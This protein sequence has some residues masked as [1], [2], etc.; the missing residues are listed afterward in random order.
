MDRAEEV[1][2]VIVIGGGPAGLAAAVWCRR[3]GLDV[4]LLEGGENP[5]GQLLEHVL[6]LVD[7]PG[8]PGIAGRELASRMEAHLRELGGAVRRR[9]T[10]LELVPRSGAFLVRLADGGEPLAARRV[11][12]A[13]GAEPRRLGVP[14]EAEMLARGERWRGSRDAGRFS[15]KPVVVV[16]SGD[17]AAENALLLARAGALVTLVHRPGAWRARRPFLE[18]LRADGR[19]RLLSGRV[20][21]IE[22]TGRV[23]AVRLRLPR[24]RGGKETEERAG[25]EEGEVTLPTAAIFVYAGMEPRSGLLAPHVRLGEG[26]VVPVDE[27]GRTD[28]PGVYAAGDVCTPAAFR[29]VTNAVGQAMRAAKGVALE[30]QAP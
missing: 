27:R 11:I 8:L 28:L 12:L 13:T 2:D 9:T 10:A 23:E 20:T 7:Y 21:A 5:G 15:G 14:G 25:A 17:R 29:S 6:P 1:R 16:G 26:G 3:L 24:E 30:L 4:L 22:G 19:V 18:A